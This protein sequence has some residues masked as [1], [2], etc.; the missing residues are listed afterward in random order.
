MED[1]PIASL[2][3]LRDALL[4]TLGEVPGKLAAEMKLA[5]VAAI[6][7]EGPTGP[8]I[9]FIRRAERTGDPWSGHMAFPGGRYETT[10]GDLLSTARRETLEEIGVDLVRDARLIG[11][12]EDQTPNSARGTIAIRPFVFELV[13][14]VEFCPNEEVSEVFFTPIAPLVAGEHASSIE[15]DYEQV[16]YTL[17]AYDLQGRIV[18]GLTYRMLQM[19][20]LKWALTGSH[21][22]AP[23]QS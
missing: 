6:L 13:S 11:M 17:P 19:L 15:V 20:F 2:P 8:E 18:W 9:L 3:P 21:L 14:P 22:A 12:L 23:R 1:G 10:D 4:A 5:A 7:R 16:R